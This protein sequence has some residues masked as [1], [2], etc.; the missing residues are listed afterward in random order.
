[1]TAFL[2]ANNFFP[3]LDH[4]SAD[5]RGA[6]TT[7]IGEFQR[8]PK[9]PGI[10]L[11]RLQNDLWSG[12]VTRDLRAILHKDGDTWVFLRVDHHDDAYRWAERRRAGRHPTTGALQVV[13]TVVREVER[14][15]EPAAPPLFAERSDGYLLSLGVPSTWLPTLR[16]IRDEQTLLSVLAH[17]PQD[18]AEFLLRLST[19]ELVTPPEPVSLYTPLLEAPAARRDF[20]VIGDEVTLRRAMEGPF[21]RWIHFLHPSQ[22]DLVAARFSGPAKVSGAAGTGKTVVAMHRA[23]HLARQGKRVLLT[24]YVNALCGNLE[25]QLR[26][27]CTPDELARIRVSTVHNQLLVVLRKQDPDLH[28][29]D[30]GA[31][32]S[33]LARA[34]REVPGGFDVDF[35][36]AEWAHVIQPQGIVTWEQ[37]RDVRRTGRG[38]ALSVR[39]RKQIW[40]VF[41]RLRE[42]LAGARKGDR[43][44]LCARAIDLL[45]SG[46][47]ASEFDAVLVDELQDLQAGELRLLKALCKSPGDLM[48]VGDAGQ[49][50]YGPGFSLSALGI[51]VRGRSYIL[52]V[53]YRTT[54]QI[55]QHADRVLGDPV[56]NL[57]G[58]TETRRNTRS[59]VQGPVPT[60]QAHRSSKAEVEAAAALVRQFIAD[61]FPASAIAIFARTNNQLD[62]VDAALA[63]LQLPSYRLRDDDDRDNATGVRLGTMHGAKGLEFRAVIV[64]GCSDK[65][66][67]HAAVLKEIQDPNDREHAIQSE[68]QLL[69]VAM[70]RARERLHLSWSGNSSR[71]IV[72][73]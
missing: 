2:F 16:E 31:I 32:K 44:A 40:Q 53:N 48:L 36:A 12:R 10:S 64:V 13:E 43:A 17:L 69:Y 15:V 18:V 47:V 25:R 51:E 73:S 70:T 55:R 3:E 29:A 6:V 52:K 67:P 49:R 66:L 39:E 72:V 11:E 21:E 7:F 45:A 1:M 4:L 60:L 59:L 5:D 71:F 22:Q 57:D 50:I 27:L 14:P 26:Q 38:R 24:S 23:R 63:A 68:R 46:K 37:Y 58:H 34:A 20:E 54:E 41:V 33:A 19:G 30:D 56:D 8:N 28:W 61:K 35:L 9:N 62:A 65:Y 42:H